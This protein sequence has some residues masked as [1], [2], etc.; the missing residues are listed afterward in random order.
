MKGG[1]MSATQD[2]CL[3]VIIPELYDPERGYQLS[4][5][6]PGC[7][8]I[9]EANFFCGHDLDLAVEFANEANLEKGYTPA[10]TTKAL[11]IVTGL[12]KI[13]FGQV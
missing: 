13:Q 8:G 1:Q 11:E 6:W 3:F 5:I 2:D 4:T 7:K 9:Q 10:F 12:S